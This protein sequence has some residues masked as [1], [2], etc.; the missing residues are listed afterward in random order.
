MAFPT[1]SDIEL[2]ENAI[3]EA[4]TDGTWRVQTMAFSDQAITL[5]SLKEA[6]ELLAS[7]KPL[8]SGAVRTRY[9]AHSKGV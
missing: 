5:R 1:Q 2:L 7:L 6:T 8:V 4:I 3:R 9:A